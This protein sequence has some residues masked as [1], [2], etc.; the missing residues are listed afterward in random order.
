MMGGQTEL[1][2]DTSWMQVMLQKPFQSSLG[3]TQTS[4][5]LGTRKLEVEVSKPGDFSKNL[6]IDPVM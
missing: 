3:H 6:E 4:Q 5:P 2:V 1:Q